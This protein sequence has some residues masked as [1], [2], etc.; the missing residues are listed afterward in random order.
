[1]EQVRCWPLDDFPMEPEND[2]I[3]S[4]ALGTNMKHINSSASSFI[5]YQIFIVQHRV[6]VYFCIYIINIL[7]YY[8]IEYIFNEK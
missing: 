7:C 2:S 6:T 8:R 3:V 4:G 1:M 5:Q